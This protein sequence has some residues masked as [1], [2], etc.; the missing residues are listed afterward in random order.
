MERV[1]CAWIISFFIYG[2]FG[3]IWE[4]L[5]C[6]IIMN[7]KIRNR[8]FL[9]GPVVP[10]YGVGALVISLLFSSRENIHSI[11]LEGAVVA[12]FI[13]YITSWAM[14]ALYHRRWWDY[15][16]KKFN[17]NGRI[18]LEGFLVFGLFSVF[19]VKYIHPAL[20]QKILENDNTILLVVIAT[21]LVTLLCVD[22]VLTIVSLIHLEEKVDSLLKE[23]EGHMQ[24]AYDEFEASKTNWNEVIEILQEME[25]QNQHKCFKNKKYIEHRIIKAFPHLMKRNK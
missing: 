20:I 24:K 25:K 5:I 3:W 22:L 18:C 23:I 8:G 6:P 4:S 11:F 7:Y 15:S 17:L 21:V 16:D 19:V 10:I 2:F 12:C 1:I 9:N 13:E 14:E